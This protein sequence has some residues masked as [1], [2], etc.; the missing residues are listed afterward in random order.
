MLYSLTLNTDSNNWFLLVNV[1]IYFRWKRKFNKKTSRWAVQEVKA[2]K[3]YNHLRRLMRQILEMRM[4]DNIGMNQS[5][6]LEHNVP[7]RISRN[8]A[9]IPH[10]PTQQLAIQQRSKLSKEDPD[11]TI[12][13]FH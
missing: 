12:D 5:M 3:T 9:A 10:P 4:N 6:A 2:K 7:R 1:I 11:K 13:C 8:I